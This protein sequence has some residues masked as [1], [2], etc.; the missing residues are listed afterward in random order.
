MGV[1]D[2]D[3]DHVKDHLPNPLCGQKQA[4]HLSSPKEKVFP[5]DLE[6]VYKVYA[7]AEAKDNDE[8]AVGDYKVPH[9]Y[10][11]GESGNLYD[12]SDD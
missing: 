7:R 11:R 4:H 10:C 2:L 12:H 6:A 1:N 9:K 5:Q 8:N 3:T